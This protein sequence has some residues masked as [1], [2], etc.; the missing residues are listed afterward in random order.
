MPYD[1]EQLLKR[2][3]AQCAHP[4]Q[5]RTYADAI[6][7]TSS[8]ISPRFV[9]RLGISKKEFSIQV[10]TSYKSYRP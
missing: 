3:C 5:V 6:S 1:A 8:V 4:G 9:P 10:A 7:I 2:A